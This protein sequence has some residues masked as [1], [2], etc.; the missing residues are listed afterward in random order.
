MITHNQAKR[1]VANLEGDP[2]TLAKI[3]AYMDQEQFGPKIWD[4]LS[5][6]EHSIRAANRAVEAIS[7][8]GAL[9]VDVSDQAARI[10]ALEGSVRDLSEVLAALLELIDR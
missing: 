8:V 5:D 1:L 2:D 9:A 7:R 10:G 3:R 6:R 4:S